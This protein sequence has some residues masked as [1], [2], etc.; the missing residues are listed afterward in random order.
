VEIDALNNLVLSSTDRPWQQGTVETSHVFVSEPHGLAGVS[1]ARVMLRMNANG[2]Y[3]ETSARNCRAVTAL[4]NHGPELLALA[5][6]ARRLV[7][8]ESEDDNRLAAREI[9][10]ALTKL[11]AV[12]LP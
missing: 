6:A 12:Q 5:R 9:A 10:I 1:S 4:V 7:T 11:E 8:A 3:A 2:R